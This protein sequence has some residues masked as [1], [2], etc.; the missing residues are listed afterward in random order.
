MHVQLQNDNGVT[1]E[2]KIG[3][4]W[5]ILFFGWIPFLFRGMPIWG[6][7]LFLC[8]SVCW[9]FPSIAVFLCAGFCTPSV[10]SIIMAFIGNKLTASY[11]LEKGYYKIGAGW[12][13]ANSKWG[14]TGLPNE[15]R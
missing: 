4:S 7:L 1:K 10:I 3:F 14:M 2:V 13:I 8:S 6:L 15:A 11:Y 5:T 12:E 9:W